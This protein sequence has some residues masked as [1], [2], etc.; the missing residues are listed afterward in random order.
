MDLLH[1][2]KGR[3]TILDIDIDKRNCR[4]YLFVEVVVVEENLEGSEEE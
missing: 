1:E 4:P 3:E 2:S